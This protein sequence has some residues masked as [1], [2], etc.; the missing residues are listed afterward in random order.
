M[1][2]GVFFV[3]TS[4]AYIN[5]PL[6]TLADWLQRAG[7]R[8]VLLHLPAWA[9]TDAA[10][11]RLL[12]ARGVRE[13]VLRTDGRDIRPETIRH[14]LT[15]RHGSGDTWERVIRDNPQVAWWLEVGNEPDIDFGP[16]ARPVDPQ[17]WRAQLLRAIDGI[18]DLA[19]ALDLKTI[20]A[21][22]TNAK[23]TSVV[24]AG[25][26]VGRRY[27]AVAVHV[28]GHREV[29]DHSPHTENLALVER[30]PSVKRVILTEVGINDPAI[31]MEEKARRLGAWASGYRG[32]AEL[33]LV[34]CTGT[35]E[36]KNYL[37][38]SEAAFRALA[39][40]GNSDQGETMRDQQASFEQSPNYTP[41]R[42]GKPVRWVIIHTT[43]GSFASAR[44]RFLTRGEEASSHYLVGRPS[45]GAPVTILQ[46][47]DERD[48]AWTAGNF[49]VNQGSVNIELVGSAAKNPPVEEEIL[50]VAADL[51]RRI[52]T[53]HGIPVRRVFRQ[54]ILAGTPGVCGHVDVPD[55]DQPQ[56]GG[57]DGRHYDP[58]PHFPWDRFLAM[59]RGE[60]A[61]TQDRL[62]FQEVP[63]VIQG[64]FAQFYQKYGGLPIFGLPLS[65]E[66]QNAE[67]VVVQ[68][69]ERAR[70]EHRPDIGRAEDWHVVLGRVN[71]ERLELLAERD[72]LKGELAALKE[73]LDEQA[74]A[75][76]LR[77]ALRQV[78][79]LVDAALEGSGDA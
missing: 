71:A 37:L 76:R 4:D 28:Y 20:A 56:F 61:V 63:F 30:D 72:Q 49:A 54:D 78:R 10:H 26:E 51:T 69:F 73:Q 38:D 57:G 74:N 2:V 41:G 75:G 8:S 68:D 58:G 32:K 70:F 46:M 33:A 12:I 21:L 52:C 42:G 48:T 18:G 36:W 35:K 19:R 62:T 24:L 39:P 47:V 66:Y 43:E 9:S 65:N 40:Q 64:G 67:R 50:R 55:P 77:E 6:A 29:G 34:F 79:A 45:P 1:R 44:A 15:R 22:P 23:D 7:L 31:P 25:G 17:T 60:Q 5:R 14:E 13:I 27:D 16:A 3:C 59:V 53:R 11:A